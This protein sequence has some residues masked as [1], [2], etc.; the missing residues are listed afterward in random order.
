MQKQFFFFKKKKVAIQ[1][2][3]QDDTI[4]EHNEKLAVIEKRVFLWENYYKLWI[5]ID[6]E[7]FEIT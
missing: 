3:Q 5:G 4:I 7:N 6:S 1:L 2:D